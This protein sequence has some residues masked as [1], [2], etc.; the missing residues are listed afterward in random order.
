MG[1][2]LQSNQEFPIT[3]L[4]IHQSHYM[5]KLI[6]KL[7]NLLK[8]LF[9]GTSESPKKVSI[10]RKDLPTFEKLWEEYVKPIKGKDIPLSNG[11]D[12]N[13]IIEVSE[14]G[15]VRRSKNRLPGEVPI[16]VFRY[17]YTTMRENPEGV[18][19]RKA[20]IHAK[21]KSKRCSSIVVAILGN[22]VPFISI[23]G[24]AEGLRLNLK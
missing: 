6:K 21:F 7:M 1:S 19:W 14:K 20:Q 15:I 16:D 3:V 17:A 10:A 8:K 4:Y 5:I 12:Y 11:K 23:I 24:K 18:V 22:S 9:T 13:H 2:G